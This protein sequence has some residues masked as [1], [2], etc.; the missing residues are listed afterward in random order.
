MVFIQIYAACS[1]ILNFE[2]SKILYEQSKDVMGFVGNEKWIPKSLLP[3]G[4]PPNF[5]PLEKVNLGPELI[6]I[7][8]TP[9]E[10]NTL[11]VIV[12]SAR[13]NTVRRGLIRQIR[14]ESMKVMWVR[15]IKTVR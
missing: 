12:K 6:R 13:D 8:K 15:N 9:C 4:T 10:E 7:P 5:A 1:S 14:D 2:P 3:S 11:P